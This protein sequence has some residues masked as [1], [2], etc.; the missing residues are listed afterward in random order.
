[1]PLE[2][3]ELVIRVTTTEQPK[4]NPNLLDIDAKINK[5]KTEIV[6]E[7]NDKMRNNIKELIYNR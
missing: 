2:I 4:N 5:I 6:R 1:M 7:L 3:R